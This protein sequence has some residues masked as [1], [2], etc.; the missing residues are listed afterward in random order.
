MSLQLFHTSIVGSSV[1]YEI[2]SSGD[3]TNLFSI[4]DASFIYPNVITKN[5]ATYFFGNQ[6]YTVNNNRIKLFKL[7]HNDDT[8]QSYDVGSGTD[9]QDIYDHPRTAGYINDSGYI[10]CFQ[11][12]PHNGQVDLWKSDNPYDISAFTEITGIGGSN[13]YIQLS[14]TCTNKFLLGIRT[15]SIQPNFDLAY[16]MSSDN[17]P[18]GTFTLQQ[19]TDKTETD[20]RFYNFWARKNGTSTKDWVV[21]QLRDESGGTPD[22]EYYATA[23]FYTTDYETF[24]NIAGT[25]SKDVT[26]TPF[27]ASEVYANYMLQGSDADRTPDLDVPSVLQVADDLYIAS[28]DVIDDTKYSL[29]YI[30]SDG[31]TS[32]IDLNTRIPNISDY[33]MQNVRLYYNGNNLIICTRNDDNGTYSSELWTADLSLNTFKRHLVRTNA[34]TGEET[35]MLPENLHEVTGTYAFYYGLSDS[36]TFDMYVTTNK[37]NH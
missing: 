29:W 24:Y 9:A 27:T 19:V 23:V 15:G 35:F 37:F 26:V 28:R 1:N 31:T 21:T 18:E 2:T 7:N 14:T 20:F 13:S 11:S 16:N 12:N 4:A 33:K 32:K 25:S 6:S 10:Y 8:F 22:N 34:W 30:Q 5:N 3:I 17:T 36:D